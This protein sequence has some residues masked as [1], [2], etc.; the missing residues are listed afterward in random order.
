MTGMKILTFYGKTE[1]SIKQIQSH[2]SVRQMRQEL[3]VLVA[4]PIYD[5]CRIPLYVQK[6]ATNV[7]I[8]REVCNVLLQKWGLAH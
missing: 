4:K 5:A 8:W 3:H 6:N 7:L 2:E 1:Q